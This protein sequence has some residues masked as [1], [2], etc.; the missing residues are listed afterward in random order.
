MLKMQLDKKSVKE[1]TRNLKKMSDRVK[2]KSIRKAIDPQAEYLRKVF[3]S[4]TPA[5]KRNHKHKLNGK[6]GKGFLK[7]SFELRPTRTKSGGVGR[8]VIVN[9]D[10]YYIFMSPNQTGRKGGRGA[11]KSGGHAYWGK[12]GGAKKYSKIWSSKERKV[13]STI[14]KSLGILIHEN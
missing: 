11:T 7:N 5:G 3:I 1:L 6:T 2:R 8:A 9:S 10:G 12:V 14:S 4:A 13:L